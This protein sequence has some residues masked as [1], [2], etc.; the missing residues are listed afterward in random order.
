[1]SLSAAE[2]IPQTVA[3]MTKA[4]GV[5]S[6]VA[7]REDAQACITSQIAKDETKQ[8]EAALKIQGILRR[9]MARK[10]FWA[11]GATEST[12]SGS[13]AI[14]CEL[15][16]AAIHLQQGR[17]RNPRFCYQCECVGGRAAS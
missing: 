6:V 11:E 16:R 15:A 2:A 7:A 10:S 8:N 5:A 13:A 4:G 3:D 17:S 12:K 9:Q 14:V 1:M